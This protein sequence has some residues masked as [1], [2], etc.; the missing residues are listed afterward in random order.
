[1]RCSGQIPLVTPFN[2]SYIRTESI[3]LQGPVVSEN[4]ESDPPSLEVWSVVEA[5]WRRRWKV[6]RTTA[7]VAVLTVGIVLLLPNKYRSTAVIL[8]DN[9]GSK[10]GGLGGLADLASMAGVSVGGGK[11]WAELYPLIMVSD[12]VLRPVILSKYYSEEL[13]DSV[14]L[15]RYFEYDEPDPQRNYDLAYQ[16]LSQS[17]DV[18]ADKKTRVVTVSLVTKDSRLG[19]AIINAM[20]GELDTFIRTKRLSNASERRKWIEQRLNDVRRDLERSENA[21]KDFRERNRVVS[22]SPQLLLEQQRLIREV[23]INSTVFIELKKQMELAKIDEINTM[24]IVSVLDA[25]RYSTIKESPKRGVI[26]VTMVLFAFIVS[27]GNAVV[28]RSY[29]GVLEAMRTRWDLL[30][31][32]RG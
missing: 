5:V 18:S 12:A 27:I 25:A 8:P 29:G 7:I 6:V 31:R 9:E 15:I 19:S 22:G 24:P 17:I 4:I 21:L 11:S 1:M 16:S 23:E 13:H 3:T 28:V 14:D 32:E 26:V 10:L 30:R 2:T 20:L